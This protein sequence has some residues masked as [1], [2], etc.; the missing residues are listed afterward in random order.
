MGVQ[1]VVDWGAPRPAKESDGKS[2]ASLR[3]L[4]AF[5][6]LHL[7]HAGKG[8]HGIPFNEEDD[9]SVVFQSLGMCVRH[10]CERERV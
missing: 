7:S 1:I 5:V 10:V 2:G 3:G 4:G 8:L 6:H 9:D